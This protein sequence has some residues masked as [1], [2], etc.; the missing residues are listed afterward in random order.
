MQLIPLVIRGL[1]GPIFFVQTSK[2]SG[3]EARGA[4]FARGGGFG[5][6]R[7]VPV[8]SLITEGGPSRYAMPEREKVT[9]II[10]AGNEAH[11]ILEALESVLWIQPLNR[12]VRRK[13]GRLAL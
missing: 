5:D 2:P 10:P 7:N 3:D 13:L 1:S 12:V 4:P 8:R 6:N 9:A 11:Q